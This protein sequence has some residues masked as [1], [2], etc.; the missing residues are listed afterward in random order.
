MGLLVIEQAA[1][2]TIGRSMNQ[3]LTVSVIIPTHNRRKS[4]QRTLDALNSQTFPMEQ[5]E[6]IVVADGCTDDTAERI[7][8]Y[9]APY[10]LHLIEQSGQ[11]AAAAR[12]HGAAQAMGQILL[13]LDDD[14]EPTAQCVEWHVRVHH[15]HP[16]LKV[17]IGPYP[18][19]P[20]RRNDYLRIELE[21]WWLAK[22]RELQEPGHRTA[23]QDLLSG[24]LSLE[25]VLFSQVSGFDLTFP[26]AGG[27]DYEFGAR[28]IKE[29]ASFVLAPEALAYHHDHET[30]DLDG[31]FRR[32]RQE[33]YTD[34]L[35][36]LR[37]P[38]LRSTQPLARFRARRLSLNH[39]LRKLAFRWPAAGDAL[40]RTIRRTLGPVERARLFGRWRHLCGAVRR[41]WYWRGVAEAL[42]GR[43]SVAEYLQ[44]G[45]ATNVGHGT[46]IEI[47]LRDGVE[48]A[49][50]ILDE[51]RPQSVCVRYGRQLVGRIPAQPGAEPLKGS[52]L[53]PILATNMAW[54]LLQA[55]ALEH[56]TDKVSE[57]KPWFPGIQT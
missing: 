33:G 3:I 14:V 4:L 35:I 11:G 48:T 27:E 49:E 43:Q 40:A 22:F 6:V 34:V 53:R 12:N 56:A 25:A 50:Q 7:L 52:H 36:G 39:I 24:N 29:G 57:V 21:T 23:Y 30:T 54:P 41:Y 46:E 13:F 18:P 16:G 37:H 45:L 38:E 28:L 1:A 44:A 2:A 19:V 9:E 10:K 20:Q 42:D 51:R 47:D 32:G 55:M 15:Q 26:S 31:H 5:L 8:R 17:V